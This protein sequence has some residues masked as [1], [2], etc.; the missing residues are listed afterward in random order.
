M[1]RIDPKTLHFMKSNWF[2]KMLARIKGLGASAV[3]G[4]SA[5]MSSEAIRFYAE[6]NRAATSGDLPT[7]ITYLQAAL[8]T[9]GGRDNAEIKKSL[10]IC[11]ANDAVIKAHRA[12]ENVNEANNTLRA[13]SQRLW[14]EILFERI[15]G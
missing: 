15:G 3:V 9:P 12:V 14:D 1:C 6:A 2:T 13:R 5:Q 11:L 7:A 10:A 8:L 4:H